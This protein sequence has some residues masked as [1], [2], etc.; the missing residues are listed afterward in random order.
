MNLV[1]LHPDF[2]SY[3]VVPVPKMEREVRIVVD[4]LRKSI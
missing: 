2:M 3:K 4:F 1:V